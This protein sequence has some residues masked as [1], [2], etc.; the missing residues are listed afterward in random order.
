MYTGQRDIP[1]PRGTINGRGCACFLLT[2]SQDAS[3]EVLRN[4]NLRWFE[5]YYR[6]YTTDTIFKEKIGRKRIYVNMT[7]VMQRTWEELDFPHPLRLILP[8]NRASMLKRTPNL[9]IDMGE[10]TKLYFSY[11]YKVSI[12]VIAKNF[13][14]FLVSKVTTEDYQAYDRKLIYIPLD[15]W[16]AELSNGVGFTREMLNN[17]LSILIF[18]S[19]KYP[20]IFSLIPKDMDIL[21]GSDQHQQFIRLNP[22]NMTPKKYSVLKSRILKLATITWNEESEGMLSRKFTPDEE[23]AE[24]ALNNE[25]STTAYDDPRNV[26]NKEPV[27]EDM[28]DEEKAKRKLREDN[29]AR[30]LNDMKRDL[31]GPQSSS[32]DL[33]KNAVK[34]DTPASP[35]PEIIDER[36]AKKAAQ[37]GSRIPVED[38]TQNDKIYDAEDITHQKEDTVPIHLSDS[39][40]DDDVEE[41]VDDELEEIQENDPDALV[42]PIGHIDVER[43]KDRVSSRIKMSYMPQHTDAAMKRMQE[44][45]SEQ[46]KVI[47]KRPTAQQAK[48]KIIDESDFSNA[49]KTSNPNITKSK[50]VNF[51]RDY[52]EKKLPYD[53]DG[54]VAKLNDAANPIFITSKTEEDSST[55]LDLKKTL[56]YQ[57]QDEH[58]GKHTIKID[59]PIII[60]DKYIYHNGQKLLLG[61]QQIMMPIVKSNPT[62]VVIVSWYNKITLRREGSNDTR[63][64]AVKRFLARNSD[65]F[66]MKLGNAVVKNKQGNYHSTLDIDMFAKQY[67]SFTIGTNHFNLDRADLLKKIESRLPGVQ[68]LQDSDH[69]PVG[70]NSSTKKVLYV[71]QTS[72]LT[73]LVLSLFDE[74]SRLS[75]TKNIKRREQKLLRT[76]VKIMSQMIPL[77]ILLCF[78]EPFETVMKKAELNYFLIDRT[79]DGGELDDVDMTKYD[80]LTCADKYIVWERN[81]LW[82]T[83]LMNGFSGVD[84]SDTTYDELGSK[85]TFSN[86][87]SNYWSSVN[88]AYSLMQFY[89]FMIDPATKEILEDYNLPTDL[90]SLMLLGNRMLADN[91]YTAISNAKAFRILSNEIIPEMIYYEVTK[92][93]SKYRKSQGKMGRN[94]KPDRITIKQSA[95]IDDVARVSSLTN[96]ASVLN[97]ILEL[98]KARSITPRGMHGVG[99][100]RAM[101]E[102][103]RAYDPSMVGIMAMTT[104]PDYKVGVNRQL[105][106]EPM[107]TSTRGYVQVTDPKDIDNLSSANLLSPSEL[108]SPP[109]ALHDDGPRTAMGYKQSQ[110]MLPVAGSAPVFFGNKVEEVIPYHMSREFVVVAK[111]DGQVVD[112]KDGII[113]VQYKDGTYDSIDTNPK[114]R[115]NASS[116]FYIKTQ[117]TTT[118]KEVGQKFKKNEIIANDPRAFTKNSNDLSASMNIGVPIKIAVIPNYD[119]YEDAAPITEKLSEKFTTYMSM[120]EEAGIPAES[121]VESIVK[122]GQRVEVGDPLIIYDPAHEDAETNAFLNEIR[123]KLGEDLTNVIDMQSMPQVRTEYA[124]TVSAIE[125]YTSVPVNELSPSLQNI[126]KDLTAHGRNTQQILTKYQNEG[127]L[128]YYKCGR[129]LDNAPEVIKPDYQ[130]RIKGVRI[131]DDGRGVAIFFYIEFKDI[132]K[133]GDKGSAF[134]ALKFVT[135]H[136]VPKGKEPYSEYRPDEEI[137]AL[138]AP[139]A[140][141]ARKTPSIIETMFTNKCIVEMTRHALDIFFDDKDF[142]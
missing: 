54:A 27:R 45:L 22:E 70:Y 115:K 31:L 75:I 73:D 129:I 67:M 8:R 103:K 21:I 56:T 16:K 76:N 55:Q 52:N 26:A 110:Y 86:L 130:N 100:E 7:R 124:G 72:S 85:E 107:V 123:E 77:A 91:E 134:T 2:P 131:G 32:S 43:V 19:Y 33:N 48:S 51:D 94:K 28:T 38:L 69:I 61:H 37:T 102:E 135:S 1:L 24:S 81:P 25:K 66:H 89:D 46:D 80:F 62:D 35:S 4:S 63:T 65:A 68:V 112:I 29:R 58:G 74:K 96:E 41:A 50:F 99:K 83:M 142:D 47:K 49:V 9:L 117:M 93:Y 137:S 15:Q 23:N 36:V 121:Y 92:A 140:I 53:I 82:N 101:T 14:Q 18:A 125:I 114:M 10:W 109:G 118:L 122:V 136:V 79:G 6:N 3:I 128:A 84:F 105:T 104:S 119:I 20:E 71:T 34:V 87:L 78:Y 111:N 132:A 113:V 30:L 108:L 126:Y 90:V 5:N 17:P 60:D 95:I 12:P 133:T 88:I 116:G 42:D 11:S 39:R 97:P 98:E 139:S 64:S 13:I 120:R 138:I 40:L 59:V 127:D 44:L 106:L 57:L 141:L